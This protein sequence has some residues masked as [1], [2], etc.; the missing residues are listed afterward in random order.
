MYNQLCKI[1]EEKNYPCVIIK[2]NP[3]FQENYVLQFEWP[4]YSAIPQ[5]SS[6]ILY[7]ISLSK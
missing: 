4:C 5:S 6:N 3:K 2:D 1:E 7:F